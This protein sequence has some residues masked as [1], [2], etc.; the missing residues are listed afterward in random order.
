MNAEEIKD[1]IEHYKNEIV[2]LEEKLK[3][4]KE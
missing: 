3:N 2:I 1:W 4:I